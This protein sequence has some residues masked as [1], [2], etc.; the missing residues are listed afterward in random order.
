[1]ERR[2]F[3]LG[4]T[5]AAVALLVPSRAP[6]ASPF[7]FGGSCEPQVVPPQREA[8]APAELVSVWFSQRSYAWGELARVSIVA[9]TNTALIE[10]RVASYGRALTRIGPGRF[11]G[12]YRL[13]FLPPLLDR[14]RIALPFRFIA[15]NAAGIP[16]EQETS[17]V[18]SG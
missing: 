3:L 4:G 15:R 8:G 1:M 17:I 2:A 14:V 5:A 11:D 13:P 10:M 6:G 7:A 16:T 12:V 9:S 18:V